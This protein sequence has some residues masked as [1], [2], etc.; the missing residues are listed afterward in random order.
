MPGI[1]TA[2]AQFIVNVGVALSPAAFAK[3]AA[4]VSAVVQF[5]AFTAASTFL[6]RRTAAFETDIQGRAVTTRGT[7]EAQKLIYGEVLVSGPLAWI[8]TAGV[9]NRDLHMVIPLA[10]HVCTSIGDVWLDQDVIANSEINGG[11]AGGGEVTTGKYGPLR[12]FNSV[13]INKYLGT[14]SQTADTMLTAA[15]PTQWT[16]NHRLR[17]I[18]YIVTKFSLFDGD[19]SKRLW[20]SGEPTNVRAIVRGKGVYDPRLDTSPGANPDNGAYY[21]WSDN[22]ALCVADFLRDSKFGLDFEADRIDW[23]AVVTAADICDGTVSVPSGTQKRYT[24]NGVISGTSTPRDAIENL[25]TSMNGSLVFTGGLWTIRA[26]AYVAPVDTLSED[27]IVGPVGIRTGLDSGARF[28]SI[29]ATY[30]DKQREYE[31]T[32][33]VLASYTALKDTRDGGVTLEKHINLPFTDNWFEAQR[34]KRLQLYEADQEKTI[35]LPCNLRALRLV[36]GES[37]NLTINELGWTPKVFQV[38]GWQFFDRGGDELGVEIEAREHI[39]AQYPDLLVGEYT[40]RT[41]AGTLVVPSRQAGAP[42]AGVPPGIRY[43]EGVWGCE[44]FPNLNGAGTPLSGSVQITAGAFIAPDGATIR[45]LAGGV[46]VNTPF[47]DPDFVP[48]NGHFFIVWGATNPDTRFGAG[49][50]GEANA[51]AAGLFTAYYDYGARQWVAVE[52]SFNR[53]EYVF[54]PANTDFVVARGYKQW[55]NAQLESA[56]GV[57][58][59][60]GARWDNDI[61]GQPA[62][63]DIL[64]EEVITIEAPDAIGWNS[65]GTTSGTF[66]P[67]SSTQ[68]ATVNVRDGTGTIVRTRTIT[69]TI[70]FSNG[71]ITV[72]TDTVD[73]I[74]VTTAGSG[75]ASVTVTVTDNASGQVHTMRFFSS[76]SA[77]GGVGK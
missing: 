37:F 43:G 19:V 60:I 27:D 31:A 70:T 1:G 36:T 75:T 23:D 65:Y 56:I 57:V 18:C 32:E 71:T 72:P 50:W 17:G 51:E 74:A 28:N 46:G 58:A 8:N 29:K 9:D 14:A 16:S 61:I 63:A 54:T 4:I 77:T 7:V 13:T 76:I 6:A 66:S 24:C 45:T 55:K 73:G 20:E 11:A 40:T 47:G 21:A 25:L 5:A 48:P 49:N 67:T 52:G 59:R 10:G 30:V 34:I 62:D 38:L 15:Y 39:A 44:V 53:D 42:G 2:V 41:A 64:N 3:T 12:G 35:T 26:G 22:P 69:G 33:T 68:Q